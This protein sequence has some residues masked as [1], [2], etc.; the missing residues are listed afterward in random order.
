M[1]QKKEVATYR[2]V[3][4]PT[5]QPV[6][7]RGGSEPL[8]LEKALRLANQDNERLGIEGENYLQALIDKDRAGAAFLPVI[9]LTPSYF[10]QQRGTNTT[11]L[12]AQT[13][14]FDVPVNGQM[15]VFN[16]FRDVANTARAGFTAEQRKQLLL[17]LQQ[18]VLLDVAQTFYQVI[19]S[20]ASVK[21]LE[22]SLALQIERVKDIE[23]RQRAGLARV[24]DVAQSQ[25]LASSARVSLIN[26]QNDVRTGRATLGVLVGS[27]VGDAPLVD[28]FAIPDG[29]G[30]AYTFLTAAEATRQ[31]L[32][33]ARAAQEAA[34]QG[35]KEALG[36][37]WP[38]VAVNANYF[39]SR[40]SIPSDSDWNAILTVNIPIFSA[41][42]IHAN[43]RTAWSQLR[44]AALAEALT[45][46]QVVEQTRVAYEN[47][48]AS[49]TRFGE[50]RA[51]LAAASEAFR[52]ADQS[53]KAGLATN[54]ERLTAQDQLLSTQLQLA[55]EEFDTKV[56]YLDL[57]RATGAL[58]VPL[59]VA[60]ATKPKERTGN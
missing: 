38:S 58:S 29:V 5:T 18:Q 33:A 13:H 30:S 9:A 56:F 39:L 43:V 11:G 46:R 36:Q 1:D 22:N 49:R 8:T 2:K 25:A 4:E 54:L 21:V 52:Q 57:V 28:S 16:G 41:G 17:D 27:A 26:A 10:A 34:E 55:S 35:V 48:A 40:E 3:L 51:Q 47:F 15:N 19:R 14:R 50:L 12:N 6:V 37:Y 32:V 45:H 59:S 20:E 24:L 31:D 23:A 7:T 42:I 60:E 53:Y 44:Q